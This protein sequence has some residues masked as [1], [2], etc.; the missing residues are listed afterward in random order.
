MLN[1]I[2][3]NKEFIKKRV[4]PFIW[5]GLRSVYLFPRKFWVWCYVVFYR[6][7]ILPKILKRKQKKERLTVVFLALNVSMWK[8]DGLFR[9]LQ[10]NPRFN[11]IVVSSVRPNESE[12]EQRLDQEKMAEFFRGRGFEFIQ[13]FDF[14]RK[15]RFPLASLSPDIIFYPQPY[16][17]ITAKE[18]EFT[19]QRDALFCYLPY[20]FETTAEEYT[21]NNAY[22]NVAW[23]IF[24]PTDLHKTYAE[25]ISQIRGKNCVITG[26]PTADEYANLIVEK[27]PWAV[28]DSRKRVIW[29]PHH[30]I[31][32][33]EMFGTSSFLE[34]FD[35][36]LSIAE[37]FRDRV[38]FA[39]KPHPMLITKL[40]KV[41][42]KKKTDLYYEK[43][44]R[45]ENSFQALGEYRD[46]FIES[47]A[48]IHDC[49]S[50][51]VE[52]LYAG[53]PVMY[54]FK[55]NRTAKESG[56]GKQAIAVHYHGHSCADIERFIEET[57]LG[58]NDPKRAEREA[59][60]Q[61]YLLPPNGQSV[62]KNILDELERGL[63]WKK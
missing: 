11:P 22:Q 27:S 32:S 50:F 10:K 4:P 21:Y 15:T 16:M 13:G 3:S 52:Y 6:A 45:M 14:E 33:R 7:I 5:C 58:G 34:Y 37:K 24:L 60:F 9:L 48:L 19:K 53:K 20:A 55:K 36:M 1:V 8:F 23:R 17:G 63:T 28:G 29:S 54:V 47:D 2:L 46:L 35:A 57:V 62:A 38:V 43:W 51:T 39:F 41:W 61:K 56:F 49:G 31:M 30:S 26:Y 18:Y 12:T 40:Y 59:F 25:A 42:G 44:A